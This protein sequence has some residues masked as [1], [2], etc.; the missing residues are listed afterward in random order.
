MQPG[1]EIKLAH[2]SIPSA[3][4]IAVVGSGYVGTVAACCFA[5]LGH[6]VVGVESDQGKLEALRAGCLPFHEADLEDLLAAG[7]QNGK[8]RFTDD[9]LDALERV[10]AVF[11]CIGTP[12]AADGSVDMRGVEAAAHAVGSA[13]RTPTLLVTKSTLPVGGARRVMAVVTEAI[14][15]RYGEAPAV[16]LVHNPEFL[17]EGSAVR[18]FLHPDRLVIGADDAEA[19]QV[20]TRLYQPILEQSFSGG[21]PGRLPAFL[22]T[23]VVTAETVKYACNA[24]LATKVSFINEMAR[25]CELV[26]AD[27]E[28]VA[29]GMGLD[30]RIAPDFLKA[31]LGWGGSCFAK[32]L[33]ALISTARCHGHDS[34]L[35]SAAVLVNERQRA[36]AV[37]RLAVALGSLQGTRIGLL[38]LAFKPGTDD[39]RDAPALDLA[40]RLLGL[41]ATVTAYDPVV[42]SV[43]LPGVNV[44]AHPH[45]VATDADAIVVATEWPDFL[46]LNLGDLR[47]RMRGD[48]L[49]DGRSLFDRDQATASGFRHLAIGRPSS[50]GLQPAATADGRDDVGGVAG[51]LRDTSF[52]RRGSTSSHTAGPHCTS[53]ST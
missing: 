4:R 53:D 51:Q 6:H 34:Q 9:Y 25:I 32:D 23:D 17:R 20:V 5:W 1:A 47:R 12:S 24:F 46:L 8:L 28:D 16:H 18:D 48:V 21:E 27:V 30:R 41:G 35:L 38:G 43:P 45:D 36:A 42:S 37:Q 39:V 22:T 29:V 19:L 2:K 7:L 13:L 31:G 52:A 49:L 26:G 10:D 14:R 11:V 3:A 44:V 33:A 15:Q 50:S 40:S